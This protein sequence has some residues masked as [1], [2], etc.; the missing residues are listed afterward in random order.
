M[1]ANQSLFPQFDDKSDPNPCVW[2]FGKGP[3]GAKCKTCKH[4]ICKHYSKRYYKCD[5]RPK[6]NGP[7]TDHRVRWNA[8]GK[9]E[10]DTIG[11]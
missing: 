5:W 7:A 3:K 10:E 8:C 6:S 2:M 9:Y 1:D 4:L 11:R